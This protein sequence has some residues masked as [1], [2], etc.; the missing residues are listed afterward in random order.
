MKRIKHLL[1][2]FVFIIGF[3]TS[4]SAETDQEACDKYR[5][6]FDVSITEDDPES[7]K[8]IYPDLPYDVWYDPCTALDTLKVYT[9]VSGTSFFP[10]GTQQSVKYRFYISFKEGVDVLDLGNNGTGISN[11]VETSIFVGEGT[12]TSQPIAV[13]TNLDVNKVGVG[14]YNLVIFNV[15]YPGQN[16]IPENVEFARTTFQ[17]RAN[18]PWELKDVK[19]PMG[20]FTGAVDPITITDAYQACVKAAAAADPDYD[21]SCDVTANLQVAYSSLD[22]VMQLEKDVINFSGFTLP[23]TG[24]SGMKELPGDEFGH[25]AQ[26][27]GE[28]KYVTRLV[29]GDVVLDTDTVIFKSDYSLEI[30]DVEEPVFVA[31]CLE[32]TVEGVITVGNLAKA[33]YEALSSTLK[34]H[35]GNG[36]IPFTVRIS[37]PEAMTDE[38]D[39]LGLGE[40]KYQDFGTFTMNTLEDDFDVLFPVATFKSVGKGTY[41]LQLVYKETGSFPAPATAM[42]PVYVS[43]KSSI[44]I[45]AELPYELV[46]TDPFELV[47]TVDAN[48]HMCDGYENAWTIKFNKDI[49]ASNLTGHGFAVVITVDPNAPE[50][51]KDVLGLADGKLVINSN[52]L[53]TTTDGASYTIPKGLIPTT[54]DYGKGYYIAQLVAVD[55]TGQPTDCILSETDDFIVDSKLPIELG[56]GYPT[57]YGQGRK[58]YMSTYFNE[59]QLFTWN[60]TSLYPANDCPVDPTADPKYTLVYLT[61][62]PQEGEVEVI[63]W[64]RSSTSLYVQNGIT[65][66]INGRNSVYF[67]LKP[68][69]CTYDI[70]ITDV[71]G[72]VVGLKEDFTITVEA[73]PYDEDKFI[74]NDGVNPEFNDGKIICLLDPT[75]SIDLF[76]SYYKAF[77]AP[78]SA[79]TAGR[80]IGVNEPDYKNIMEEVLNDL[81]S[82]EWAYDAGSDKN[83]NGHDVYFYVRYIEPTEAD[84][85]VHPGYQNVIPGADEGK[86]LRLQVGVDVTS[87]VWEYTFTQE[88]Y[89]KYEIYP[90]VWDDNA[91]APTAEG[92]PVTFTVDVRE[93][94]RQDMLEADILNKVYYRENGSDAFGELTVTSGELPQNGV[95]VIDWTI[96]DP[97]QLVGFIH[98]P[99]CGSVWQG[100]NCHPFSYD[101]DQKVWRGKS[102]IDYDA[103]H[104]SFIELP[105]IELQNGKHTQEPLIIRYRMNYVDIDCCKG[106]GPTWNNKCPGGEFFIVVKPENDAINQSLVATPVVVDPVCFVETDGDYPAFSVDFSA[107]Y[108]QE[109]I[110]ENGEALPT[111]NTVSYRI[112]WLSGDEI[113][114]ILDQPTE[115]STGTEPVVTWE[116]VAV[117]AGK[118]TYLVTPVFDNTMN[119]TNGVAVAFTLEARNPLAADIVGVKDQNIV[120]YNG[121]KVPA[122]QLSANLPADINVAWELISVSDELTTIG[123]TEAG[124]NVIPAF[125]AIN[126]TDAPVVATYEFTVS[127]A[128]G[129]DCGSDEAV[130]TFTITVEPKNVESKDLFVLPVAP[131][132]LCV[133]EEDAELIFVAEDRNGEVPATYTVEFVSGEDVVTFS[134][135]EVNDV[136][137]WFAIPNASKTGVGTYKVTPYYNNFVGV[138]ATFTVTVREVLDPTY[139]GIYNQT[140]IVKNG[141]VVAPISLDANLPEGAVVSWTMELP[142]DVETIG[143]VLAG[144]NSITGFTAVNTT[145][146]VVEAIVHFV[147]TYPTV[148]GPEFAPGLP[149]DPEDGGHIGGGDEDVANCERAEGEFAIQVVPNTID[150]LDLVANAINVDVVCV[151]EGAT[152]NV[153]MTADYLGEAITDVENLAF[154]IEFVSGVNVLDAAETMVYNDFSANW[155]PK[156]AKAGVG[157]YRAIPLYLNNQGVPV[158]FTLEARTVLTNTMVGVNGQE[159]VYQN[160]EVVAPIQLDANLPE[161]AVVSWTVVKPEGFVSVG[162]ADAGNNVVPGFTAVN[163]SDASVT[164]TYKFTVAYADGVACSETPVTGEFKITVTKNTIEDY[165]LVAGQ[166]A[167]DAICINDEAGFSVNFTA[168]HLGANVTA[169]A[170]YRVAFVSGTNVVDAIAQPTAATWSQEAKYA[171]IGTYSVTPIYDNNQGVAAYFTIEVREALAANMLSVAGETMTYVNGDLVEAISLNGKFPEGVVVEWTATGD[172]IGMATSGVDV[173]PAFRAANTTFKT[174]TVTVTATIKYA[175]FNECAPVDTTFTIKVAPRVVED[176]DLRVAPIENIDVCAEATLPT[177][178]LAALRQGDYPAFPGADL[179]Q[180]KIEYLSGDQVIDLDANS[181]LVK[182]EAGATTA[183]FTPTASGLTGNGVYRVTPIW[184]NGQGLAT[185]FSI[186]VR[187]ALVAADVDLN[188]VE[189]VYENGDP[190]PA[191]TLS[192]NYPQGV[193]V[194]WENIGDNIGSVQ[195]GKAIIPAFTAINTTG[196]DKVAKYQFTLSYAD[197]KTCTTAQGTVSVRVKANSI[198]DLDLVMTPVINADQHKCNESVFDKLTF[199]AERTDG[200]TIPGAVTYTVSFVEGDPILD[201]VASYQAKSADNAVAAEWQPVQATDKYGDNYAGTGIYRVT[202]SY[203]NNI[204]LPIFFTLTTY[205]ELDNSKIEIQ[206]M[207]YVNGQTTPRVDFT[208][209]RLPEGVTIMWEVRHGDQQPVVNEPTIIGSASRGAN[210]MPSFVAVNDTD[211]AVVVNYIAWMRIGECS[212][213]D[214]PVEFSITVEPN[215][216]YDENFTVYAVENQAVCANEAFED[217]ALKAKHEFGEISGVKFRIEFVTDT[218]VLELDPN[219]FVAKANDDVY[220]WYVSSNTSRVVGTGY[221]RVTPIIGNSYGRA[222]EFTLTRFAKPVVN[223]VDDVVVNNGDA[224][225]IEFTSNVDANTEYDW[226]AT[227]NNAGIPVAG[228]GAIRVARVSNITDAPEVITVTVTPRLNGCNGDVVTFKVTVNPKTE[229]NADI[230]M[231]GLF[232]QT[233]CNN[234]VFETIKLEAKHLFNAIEGPVAFKVELS[235]DNFLGLAALD[236]LHSA[237][238][239][240]SYSWDVNTA[241]NKDKEG[242]VT[243]T[244]TPFVNNFYGQSTTFTLT[245]FPAPQVD[246]IADIELCNGEG[247]DVVFT[248]KYAATEYDWTATA[249]SVG[250]PTSGSQFIKIDKLNNL[251]NEPVVVTITV[252]PRIPGQDC[253][254]VEAS[255]ET[256]TVT[257]NPTVTI[258]TIKN[259]VFANSTLVSEAIEITGTADAYYYEVE[260]IHIFDNIIETPHAGV[261]TADANGK[262]FFPDFTTTNSTGMIMSK[263]TVTP[264]YNNCEGTTISFYIIVASN[265]YLSDMAD[266]EACAG[267]IVPRFTHEDLPA[268][269]AYTV[270]YTGGAAIG[271]EDRDATSR[272]IDSFTAKE[273]TAVITITPVYTYSGIAFEGT[274]VELTFNVYPRLQINT[275]GDLYRSLCADD[276]TVLAVEVVKG[277]NVSYQWYRGIEP[278]NGAIYDTYTV[279]ASQAGRD[280]YSCLV[281]SRCDDLFTEEFVVETKVDVVFQVWDDVMSVNCIADENGGYTF[282]SFKWYE[283]DSSTGENARQMAS[284]LSWTADVVIGKYY[285]IVA[286]TTNGKYVSCP[287]EAVELQRSAIT[288]APNPVEAGGNITVT[289]TNMSAANIYISNSNGGAVKTVTNVEGQV[290]IAMPTLPGIYVINVVPVDTTKD[291]AQYKVIVK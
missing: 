49:A 256:F 209:D 247:L 134:S 45:E 43:D 246:P 167:G 24:C 125:T 260:N 213:K 34:G 185:T 254:G 81:V 38:E 193:I 88:G 182:A 257:V 214:T 241:D 32:Q 287:V 235:G 151:E 226:T 290:D 243:I 73:I 138:P 66:E 29:V 238:K 26:M 164:V 231:V 273:G 205:P 113:I 122:T 242:S 177:V 119:L 158:T 159:Y 266:M 183:V 265:L 173:I 192:G 178:A 64:K 114:D 144:N 239:L 13:F 100:G 20:M 191:I 83:G 195:K 150:D 41:D 141:D 44:T 174:K 197:G 211:E 136:M 94:L 262:F 146:E 282:T 112:E 229:Y 196:A 33:A 140:I 91:I 77:K 223:A 50:G 250:I 204:G 9:T 84:L 124:D 102:V 2:L 65:E 160:G 263:V 222:I 224:L 35:S 251:T 3:G 264:K 267:D 276:E 103:D 30:K 157:V 96:I 148:G 249:N 219:Q 61:F 39:V 59:G 258:D 179:V 56:D 15:S 71:N 70:V 210:Y 280:T 62:T 154:R 131:V 80:L 188:D 165:D 31:T 171:G 47:Y 166:V 152:F 169:D 129:S 203:G 5:V 105:V 199:K 234:E 48:L 288:V 123:S 126:T 85:E 194:K 198:N 230:T 253:P 110:R 11:S 156:V 99:T 78:S 14:T 163:V 1:L 117:K 225:N 16:V 127:Y 269:V 63:D 268:G 132:A 227:A 274:P 139:V 52:Q 128:D 4:A 285:F 90:V 118:G 23:R 206:D 275:V 54:V 133:T 155:T 42:V 245:R 228:S 186:N 93:P 278:I 75:H 279:A 19:D 116:P 270:K 69:T 120:V 46:M 121:D 67:P 283:S 95:I 142:A 97:N 221:Y 21:F 79:W 130:G 101:Q 220:N 289:L 168:T 10:G 22:D 215:L 180:F 111:G 216:I 92:T 207:T 143:S 286:T 68:G 7:G 104:K 181:E 149:G 170:K 271:L 72:K 175:D 281:S 284:T 244:V 208:G 212:T 190:V 237:G 202:P 261:I 82:E 236:Y 184:A 172:A 217:I 28:G 53:V 58:I 12:Y 291:A 107:I 18:S 8:D 233:I 277:H 218:D 37:R 98:E 176:F 109:D 51:H 87:D 60:V 6:C 25:W 108:Q 255:Q 162:T 232:D 115:V 252:T 17:V 55:A 89:A 272:F 74:I 76:A 240:L 86:G 145:A 161:G 135:T 189:L 137:T 153:E 201:L 106:D 27:N 147:I 248:S 200:V 40:G 187:K 57:D 259:Q 36:D